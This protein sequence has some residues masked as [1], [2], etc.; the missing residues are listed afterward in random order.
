MPQPSWV[1]IAALS[2]FPV[3]NLPYG[4]A[5]HGERP[6]HVVTRIGDFAVSLGALALS[7][8]LDGTIEEPAAYF[9]I[10]TLNPFMA[11]GAPA[12]AAVRERLTEL[13]PDPRPRSAVEPFLVPLA[14]VVLYLPFQ[15]A[16]Y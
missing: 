11:L 7:G 8:L 1:P 12:W 4:V 5:T 3:E 6:A 13:S 15:V 2:A 16:D 10:G 9:A 14:E